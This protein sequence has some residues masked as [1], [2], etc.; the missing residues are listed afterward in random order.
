MNVQA[1]IGM[2]VLHADGSEVTD[3]AMALA[4]AQIV[5]A[6][7]IDSH[8]TGFTNSAHCDD[9]PGSMY[10]E[11]SGGRYLVIYDLDAYEWHR[12]DRVG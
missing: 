4:I 1:T 6:T 5:T 9:T 7:F 3:R 2:D 11:F 12:K 10:L 8:C